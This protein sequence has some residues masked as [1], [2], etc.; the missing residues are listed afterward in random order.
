MV[1]IVKLLTTNDAVVWAEE[2]VRTK[3]EQNW[4]L[5]DIDEGLMVGW[6]AN[7]MCAQ[8]DFDQRKSDNETSN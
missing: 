2:F 5:D 7:A 3:K 6:F 4:T 8:M 1:S